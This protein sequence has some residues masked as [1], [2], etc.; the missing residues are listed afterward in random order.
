MSTETAVKVFIVFIECTKIGS[1]TV[2]ARQARSPRLL[3][4]KLPLCVFTLIPNLLSMSSISNT[5]RS[6]R[7]NPTLSLAKQQ[8]PDIKAPSRH[9]LT[10]AALHSHQIL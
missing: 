3:F 7:H 8:M 9:P 6:S 10:N 4:R 1:V 5:K 2:L